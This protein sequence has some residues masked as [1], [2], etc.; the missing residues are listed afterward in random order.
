M[1]P[2]S[3]EPPDRSDGTV[4]QGTQHLLPPLVTLTMVALDEASAQNWAASRSN[5]AV[6]ILSESGAPFT[7]ALQY[8][9]DMDTLKTYLT[10]QKLNYRVFTS[11]LVLRNAQWDANQF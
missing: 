10:Q 5:K 6:D 8:S 2:R 7:T 9:S 11:T 1:R 4:N 3:S